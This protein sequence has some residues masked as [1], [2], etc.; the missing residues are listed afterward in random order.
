MVLV[1]NIVTVIIS[2]AKYVVFTRGEFSSVSYNSLVFLTMNSARLEQTLGDAICA[3]AS[4]F[5]VSHNPDSSE[6]EA[7]YRWL[8]QNILVVDI[9]CIMTV[10]AMFVIVFLVSRFYYKS[11]TISLWDYFI[12]LSML[13]Y[14]S[15]T[16]V[17]LYHL[18]HTLS[19]VGLSMVAIIVLFFNT[20]CLPI[21]IYVIVN[22][23]R[24]KF[25]DRR[26][27]YEYGSMY[28]EYKPECA[29][30]SV[31]LLLKQLVYAVLSVLLTHSQFE[32]SL[33]LGC[34]GFVNLIYAG[35]LWYYKPFRRTVNLIQAYV[36]VGIKFMIIILLGINLIPATTILNIVAFALNMCIYL[37]NFVAFIAIHLQI[38]SN[39]KQDR[40]EELIK[41]HQRL[42]LPFWVVEE[43][44]KDKEIR[45]S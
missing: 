37:S 14:Y 19:D 31:L 1:W 35:T 38:R 43:Y 13:S 30:F 32:I 3:T 34:Q 12:R 40:T 36:I 33:A 39:K 29:T 16:Y 6:E 23:N 44:M 21:Y 9:S 11:S 27:Q 18:T 2:V 4:N 45:S 25:R 20:I 15:L 5:F 22:G 28:L 26:F 8:G 41:I 10:Y 42:E 7:W 24:S 17:S